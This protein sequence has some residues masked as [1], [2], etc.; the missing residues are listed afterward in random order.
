[1]GFARFCLFSNHCFS[2]SISNNINI[3]YFPGFL[4][5]DVFNVV[6]KTSTIA[7]FVLISIAK[8][9][10]GAWHFKSFAHAN[11]R[12]ASPGK[13]VNSSHQPSHTT[14]NNNNKTIYL[15]SMHQITSIHFIQLYS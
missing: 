2:V 12:T 11:S 4:V 13:Q 6:V 3:Q 10:L 5:V 7:W 14:N 1:M 15:T 9:V 8:A